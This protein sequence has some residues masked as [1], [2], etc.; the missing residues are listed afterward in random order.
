MF[1]GAYWF[2]LLMIP[3]ILI[4]LRILLKYFVNVWMG[5][6]WS[7]HLTQRRLMGRNELSWVGSQEANF[8]GAICDQTT[9]A[10]S[11]QSTFGSLFSKGHH[12]KP[13][14]FFGHKTSCRW[15][16]EYK[17][18]KIWKKLISVTNEEIFKFES[19]TSVI[20]QNF[21]LLQT[22]VSR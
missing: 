21:G 13:N 6:Q 5:D 15:S 22:S 12:S 20:R 11:I 8:S 4:C 7:D 17:N 3:A 14:N 18:F 10:Q 19:W 16:L 2:S 1:N 9:F